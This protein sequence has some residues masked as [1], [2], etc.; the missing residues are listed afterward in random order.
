M[1]GWININEII[2][3]FKQKKS[4]GKHLALNIIRDWFQEEF[5]TDERIDVDIKNK[6]LEVK[7]ESPIIA[8]EIFLRKEKIRESIN[9]LLKSVQKERKI[10]FSDQLIKDIRAKIK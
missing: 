8:Q 10:D 9:G 4:V 1:D 3:N 2:S 5:K 6:L 7:T